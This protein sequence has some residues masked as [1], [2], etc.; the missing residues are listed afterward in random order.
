MITELNTITSLIE[1]FLEY[2]AVERACSNNTL[3]SYRSDLHQFDEHVNLTDVNQI[4]SR[5][6]DKYVKHLSDKG[7]LSTTKARKL[8][9]IRSFVSYL[10][11]EGIIEND[12]TDL[13]PTPKRSQHLPKVLKLSDVKKLLE[14]PLDVSSAPDAMRD[15]AMLQIA[16]ASGLRVSEIIG[17]DVE[18]I[19]FTVGSVR[20]MGKGSKER[21]V[22]VH[23]IALD[24][25]DR[26]VRRGRATFRQQQS[27]ALFLNRRGNRLTRQGFWGIVKKYAKLIGLENS[28][29]PHTLRHSFATHL[30]EGGAPIRHVQELLGHASISTTQIYTHLTVEF[31]RDQYDNAHPRA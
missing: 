31:V 13:I 19:D 10:H 20:C 7:Y 15:A 18:N 1:D 27:K 24:S 6:I 14:L 21:I 3:L 26:Y 5:H 29:T 9:S 11:S 16:Y 17:L 30:L 12:P 4:T 25:I 8:A 22:P 2:L 28:M 23:R